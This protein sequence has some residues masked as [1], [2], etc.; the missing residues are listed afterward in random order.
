MS[1]VTDRP[2]DLERVVEAMGTITEELGRIQTDAQHASEALRM[3]ASICE[4][5]IRLSRDVQ[6]L[7]KFLGRP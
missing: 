2:A 6:K 4:G 7:V 5:Q 3:I 1:T